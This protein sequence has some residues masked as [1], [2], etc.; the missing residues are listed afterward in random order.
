MQNPYNTGDVL[1]QQ[2]ISSAVD[3]LTPYRLV[4]CHRA[5]ARLR[6]FIRMLFAGSKS[7]SFSSVMFLS[8]ISE[9]R[10]PGLT[11]YQGSLGWRT[12]EAPRSFRERHLL[13][14]LMMQGTLDV[15]RG[16]HCFL[17]L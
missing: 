5:I 2:L 12:A 1:S 13:K 10:G 6:A 7:V 9:T 16:K 8:E 3:S 15:R 11:G 14:D 4:M 17:L